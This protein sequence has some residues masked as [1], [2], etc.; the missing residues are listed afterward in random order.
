MK[1]EIELHVRNI[2]KQVTDRISIN[3]DNHHFKF[4]GIDSSPAPSKNV[5]SMCRVI[6][7]LGVKHF[8]ASGTVEC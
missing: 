6:E 5:S 8:G 2:I 7:L 1:N 4:S 3:K